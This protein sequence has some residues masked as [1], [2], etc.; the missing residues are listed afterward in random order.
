MARE[1][2]GF[3]GLGKSRMAGARGTFRVDS[4]SPTHH[5]CGSESARNLRPAIAPR[6]D[7][8]AR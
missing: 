3:C 6:H 7:P 8:G 2:P 4:D 1:Y 5:H